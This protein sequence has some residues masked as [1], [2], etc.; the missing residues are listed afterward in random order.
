MDQIAQVP[1]SQSHVNVCTTDCGQSNNDVVVI[2]NVKDTLEFP[3]L[4]FQDT[5]TFPS[6]FDGINLRVLESSVSPP[7]PDALLAV[8][9]KE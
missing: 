4:V 9:Q 5:Y 3:L 7:S 6:L 1:L 2:Q 8:A